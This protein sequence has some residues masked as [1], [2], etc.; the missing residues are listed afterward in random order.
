MNKNG[1]QALNQQPKNS[2][3]E[4]L[5]GLYVHWPYCVSKCPYCDFNSHVKQVFSEQQYVKAICAELDFL[6]ARGGKLRPPLGSIFFGGGTPS[7]M[8]PATVAAILDHIGK[9]FTLSKDIEITLEANPSS[10]EASRFAELGEVGINRVSLGV[11]ALHDEALHLLGRAHGVS[12]ALGAIALAQ[13][14]FGRMSFD[15]IYGRHG[16]ELEDWREEL[17]RG[18]DLSNGHLS[19]YQLT[20]EEGTQYKTAFDRGELNLPSNERAV[21]FFEATREICDSAGMPAYEISNYARDGE[22]SVHN[23][24]YWRY[25]SYMGIGPG[26]HGRVVVEG[27]R[28]ATAA[29]RSPKRW[30]AQV[31]KLGHGFETIDAL[32]STEQADEMVLMGMRLTTGLDLAHLSALTQTRINAQVPEQLVAAGLCEFSPD[33]R[34]LRASPKGMPILNLIVEQLSLAL[35]P[36]SDIS[37][38]V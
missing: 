25:G 32:S 37:E 12:E 9:S 33:R 27:R 7:L 6:V 4:L 20:I 35:E 11:Q 15:L 1:K 28:L 23:L 18:I 30:L 38:Q 21:R 22:Q 14:H 36:C 24:V 10:V 13:S 17:K 34:H 2:F 29:L 16:Q 3:G 31:E 26:A 8:Q 5:P 19:L